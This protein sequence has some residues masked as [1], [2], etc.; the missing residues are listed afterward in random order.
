MNSHPRSFLR[1]RCGRWFAVC[2][3][4]LLALAPGVS[5]QTLPP[6]MP[7]PGFSPTLPVDFNLWKAE[8]IALALGV[9][10]PDLPL[11]LSNRRIEFD[12][13][14]GIP[15][16]HV[17]IT[18]EEGGGA[19]PS[20]Y[21]TA[22][23]GDSEPP[24]ETTL[25]A[26]VPIDQISALGT[27]I[28]SDF[29]VN[30]PLLAE[31]E[32]TTG[33]GPAVTFARDYRIAGMRGA[34]VT[35]AVI[36]MGFAGFAGAQGN[37]DAPPAA[38][39]TVDPLGHVG[40]ATVTH[41]TSCVEV[42]YDY[43]YDATYRLYPVRSTAHLGQAV[44]DIIAHKN[45]TGRPVIISHSM[46]W[47]NTG[48]RDGSGDACKAADRAAA[49]D[50]PFVTASGNYAM[51]HYQAG[52]IL[53]TNGNQ[54]HEFPDGTEDIS[55]NVPA[56]QNATFYL[57]WDRDA[58]NATNYDLYLYTLNAAGVYAQVAS[59]TNWSFLNYSTQKF[60]SITWTNTAAAAQ[61]VYL[62]VWHQGGS[63]QPFEVFTTR[64]IN[65]AAN[66][67]AMSSTA[68]PANAT[69]QLVISVAAINH[70][71]YTPGAGAGCPDTVAD[72]IAPY[73]SQGP[74][75]S[76]IFAVS[77][78]GPTGQST[79]TNGANG[80]HGTSCATPSVAAMMALI[81]SGKP[82]LWATIRDQFYN[83]AGRFRDWPPVGFDRWYGHGGAILPNVRIDI[84]PNRPNEI[85]LVANRPNTIKVAMLG[86]AM[87][88]G[89]DMR[90]STLRLVYTDSY[91]AIRTRY[92]DVNADGFE[93]A[94]IE[95]QLPANFPP[96]PRTFA[97]FG[98]WSQAY[99]RQ[100]P[101]AGIET[102]EVIAPAPL[103]VP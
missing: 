26:R 84:Q 95:F 32:Q 64:T 61:T 2:A 57:Q 50:I 14:G 54:W 89:S 98:E 91:N 59:S 39:V 47:F 52:G 43:V 46:A 33:E 6:P 44:D 20:T 63:S 97:L 19:L 40:D 88:L 3:A 68:S 48:W 79:F 13:V 15:W 85:R 92:L 51:Q 16:L 73:S 62:G 90:E 10:N 1:P 71:C 80:F 55:V 18:G 31:V 70:L 77:I 103:P 74:T 56:G 86:S 49:A 102:I 29:F 100:L 69:N 37:M 25:P 78:S 76:G 27:S 8:Q 66:R 9:S 83:W 28:P 67:T 65:V 81:R 99:G 38:N 58:D 41:G 24:W 72:P 22:V 93:D 60:E 45:A 5:A 23:G 82:A 96:G 21:V 75:N 36:D 53:D 34:G 87:Y 94:L 12:V 4:A 7:D 101:W 17:E 42:I 30:R 35:I 11:E